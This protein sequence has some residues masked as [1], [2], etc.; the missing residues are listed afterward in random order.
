MALH[1]ARTL[2]LGAN[3][4]TKDFALA[5][6]RSRQSIDLRPMEN[7][8]KNGGLMGFNGIYLYIYPLVNYRSY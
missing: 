2:R 7:N 4:C 8:R 5:K 1:L 6:R 3:G